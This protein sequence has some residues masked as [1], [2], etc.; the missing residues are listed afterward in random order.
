[1]S[2]NIAK[3]SKYGNFRHGA[4]LESN[5]AILGIGTNNEKYCSVGA[6]YHAKGHGTYHAEISAVLNLDR[7]IT[8]GA[9]IYVSRVSKKDS[10]YRMSKPCDMCHAV[11]QERGIKK[12]VYSVDED[13][14][15]FYKF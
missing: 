15:G 1:M 10:S 8:K 12:V 13:T 9:T 3:T 14:V 11:L 4:V 2:K 6:K 7:S 5:G